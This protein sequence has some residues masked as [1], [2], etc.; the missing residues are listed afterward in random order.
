M[1]FTDFDFYI[2]KNVTRTYLLVVICSLFVA[3]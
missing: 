1:L 3:T 2:L